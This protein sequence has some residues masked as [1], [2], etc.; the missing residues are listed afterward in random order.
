MTSEDLV[1]A[2]LKDAHAMENTLITNL[3]N[4]AKDAKDHPEIETRLREHAAQTQR[5]AD[6]LQ[7]CIERHGHTT[8][9]A[10]NVLGKL[11][12]LMGNMHAGTR[13]EILK[14]CL[15]DAA[16]EHFEIACYKS[17]IT[18]ARAIGDHQTAQACEEILHDEQVMAEWLEQNIPALTTEQLALAR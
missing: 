15:Q 17:L 7:E 1:I 2:W 9:G 4:H 13:D 5:H 18:A 14:N 12:G 6:L 11:A 3:N 8:S 16:A 10:K